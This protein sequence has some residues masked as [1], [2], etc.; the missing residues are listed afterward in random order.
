MCV[1]QY[2]YLKVL[3]I[4]VKRF[5]CLEN[6]RAH[7]HKATLALRLLQAFVKVWKLRSS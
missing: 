3:V 4:S 2:G 7:V 1:F 6:T 5:L